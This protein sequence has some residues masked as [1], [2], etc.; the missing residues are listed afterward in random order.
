[1]KKTYCNVCGN[2]IPLSERASRA[3]VLDIQA[4]ISKDMDI[5]PECR[6]VGAS[7]DPA[8]ILLAAWKQAANM[9]AG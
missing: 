1:M 6:M 9:Q 3:S 2:E 7:M 8:E 5:C 4:A